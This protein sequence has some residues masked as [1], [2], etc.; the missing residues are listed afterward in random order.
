MKYSSSYRGRLGTK[1][2]ERKLQKREDLEG[3][4]VRRCFCM[5]GRYS[6]HDRFT[7]QQDSR[8]PDPRG[9]VRDRSRVVL[10]LVCVGGSADTPQLCWGVRGRQPGRRASN[11]RRYGKLPHRCLESSSLRTGGNGRHPVRRDRSVSL[12]RQYLLL[13]LLLVSHEQ[14]ETTNDRGAHRVSPV[15]RFTIFLQ[16]LHTNFSHMYLMMGLGFRV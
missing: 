6:G 16:P 12:P 11:A 10:G 1:V 9:C 13:P 5:K 3:I 4:W 2:V 7:R 14:L 8:H 15:V